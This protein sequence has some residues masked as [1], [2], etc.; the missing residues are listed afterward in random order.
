MTQII[1]FVIILIM[2]KRISDKTN[3]R[4]LR[5]RLTGML[6]AR[7]VRQLSHDYLPV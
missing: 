2:R 5:A 7:G 6:E 4:T 1:V 3:L